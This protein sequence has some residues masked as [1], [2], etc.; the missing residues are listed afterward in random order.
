M[1]RGYDIGDVR[2][3]RIDALI[4]VDLI[5]FPPHDGMRSFGGALAHPRARP[6]AKAGGGGMVPGD[7]VGWVLRPTG[8][9]VVSPPYLKWRGSGSP[10]GQWRHVPIRKKTHLSDDE[11]HPAHRRSGVRPLGRTPADEQRARD[12]ACSEAPVF[13]YFTVMAGAPTCRR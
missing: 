1:H 11:A 9:A 13:Q 3:E 5:N 12:R 2:S 6:H 4:D 8:E 7:P 10:P